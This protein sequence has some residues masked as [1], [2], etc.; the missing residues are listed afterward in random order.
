[1]YSETSAT[2]TESG[3]QGGIAACM[4]QMAGAAVKMLHTAEWADGRTH[5]LWPAAALGCEAQR[6]SLF[7][8]LYLLLPPGLSLQIPG[9]QWRGWKQGDNPTGG[10]PHGCHCLALSLNA[11]VMDSSKITAQDPSTSVPFQNT[12]SRLSWDKLKTKQTK[13]KKITERQIYYLYSLFGKKRKL[14]K[15]LPCLF[16]FLTK[17][18]TVW[19]DCRSLCNVS[20]VSASWN[21]GTTFLLRQRFRVYPTQNLTFDIFQCGHWLPLEQCFL[22]SLLH[23]Q[24][25]YVSRDSIILTWQTTGGYHCC[26]HSR[27]CRRHRWM[28]TNHNKLTMAPNYNLTQAT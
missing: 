28:H 4:W 26:T 23:L 21:A 18:F 25:H 22:P 27:V 3:G 1:M 8:L 10:W 24:W 5:L 12:Q 16:N 20:P 15:Y 14:F 6:A 7:S 17:V 9:P 2:P 11:C 19:S 13:T